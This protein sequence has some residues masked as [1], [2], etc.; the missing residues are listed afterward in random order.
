LDDD[1]SARAATVAPHTAAIART[2]VK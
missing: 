1:E 2:P